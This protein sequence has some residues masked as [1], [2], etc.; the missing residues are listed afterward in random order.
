MASQHLIARPERL[1]E[2]LRQVHRA[3]LSAGAAESDGQI[4]PVVA[5]VIGKPARN[6]MI[7]VG[8]HALDLGMAL[9]IC[10]NRGV[11]A[12]PRCER[13]LVMRI[14]ET[15][16]V[17]HEVGIERNAVLESERLKQQCQLR[18]VDADEVLDPRAQRGRGNLAGVEAVAELAHVGK[19]VALELDRLLE[20]ALVAG[21]W[22][23]P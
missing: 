2:P 6:K 7:N 1:C 14:G 3:M 12:C 15:A 22:M 10:D 21:K 13:W 4:V 18:G 19:A 9:E 16:N 17:E 20:R 5:R 8:V 11:R 23:P